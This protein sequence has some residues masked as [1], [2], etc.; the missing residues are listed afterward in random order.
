MDRDCKNCVH[1][2]PD[3]C[4]SWECEYIN[5]DEAIECYEIVKAMREAETYCKICN[6]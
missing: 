3:G 6:N 4:E 5:R 1:N 2:T